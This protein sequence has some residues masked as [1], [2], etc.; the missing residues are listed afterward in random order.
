MDRQTD[1]W[2][3]FLFFFFFLDGQMGGMMDGS[4][5]EWMSEWTLVWIYGV[6]RFYDVLIVSYCSSE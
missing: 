5:E 4:L 2:L 1:E 3:A 6:E